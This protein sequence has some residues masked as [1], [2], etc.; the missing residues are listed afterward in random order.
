[1]AAYSLT[2]ET[3]F[4]DRSAKGQTSSR[5]IKNLTLGLSIMGSVGNI[6]VASTEL[7]TESDWKGHQHGG[8]IV[9]EKPDQDDK[10]GN[11]SLAQ[12]N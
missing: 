7:E 5:M 9:V 8:E 12:R 6:L 1:M 2:V 3:D 10:L 11:Q 4:T